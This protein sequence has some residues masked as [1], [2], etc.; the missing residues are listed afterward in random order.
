[1][2]TVVLTPHYVHLLCKYQ[3]YNN[4][5][6][7]LLALL[8]RLA[9]LLGWA[10][11]CSPHHKTPHSLHWLT[12]WSVCTYANTNSPAACCWFWGLP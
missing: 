7:L 3:Q 9:E 12:F 1:M 8:P 6:Q 10:R 11:V 2:P 5:G 4:N